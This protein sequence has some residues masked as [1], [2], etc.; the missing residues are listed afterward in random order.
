VTPAERRAVRAWTIAALGGAVPGARVLW[1]F[2]GHPQP[3]RAFAVIR[4][5]AEVSES[6]PEVV[7][8]SEESRSETQV[9]RVT[10]EVQIYTRIS[11]TDPDLWQIAT[12]LADLMRRHLR[13]DSVGRVHL[14]DNGIAVAGPAQIA[15]LTQLVEGGSVWESRAA[16]TF[17][18]RARRRYDYGVGDVEA[19]A[20]TLTA[21]NTPDSLTETIDASG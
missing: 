8:I 9:V 6:T 12:D 15:D 11:E 1:P 21:Y 19:V 13:S 20:G 7:R 17:D 10:I 4:P 3:G 2:Q 18:Y 16:L 5:L 14:A